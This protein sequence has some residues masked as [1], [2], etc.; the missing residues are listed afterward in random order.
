MLH[1]N[2]VLKILIVSDNFLSSSF[3]F[4]SF[5]ILLFILTIAI[6]AI[7][8]RMWLQ[9]GYLQCGRIWNGIRSLLSGREAQDACPRHPGWGG[10]CPPAPGGSWPP[11]SRWRRT[12]RPRHDSCWP[13]SAKPWTVGASWCSRLYHRQKLGTQGTSKT[14]GSCSPEHFML[15]IKLIF[16]APTCYHRNSLPIMTA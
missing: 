15:L 16:V 14:G 7:S 11:G 8:A 12:G 10:P 5:T 2:Q 4:F 13:V 1:A 6:V 3:F 9:S